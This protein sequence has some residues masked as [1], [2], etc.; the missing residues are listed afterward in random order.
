MKAIMGLEIHIHL[1]T[2]SKLFCSC[3]TDYEEKKP[4]ENTCPICLGFPGSKPKVNKSAIDFGITVAKALNC[5]ILSEMFFSRKSYFY[6]DMPKNFQ[7]SQ[8]E[9][10]LAVDGF[11]KISNKRINIRRIHL[12]EDPGKLIHVGGDITTAQ[13]VLVDYNRSGIPL[14]EVV[15]EP[16]F[17]STKEVREFLSKLSSILEH[18]EV[19]DSS[20]EGSMRV[21]ANISLAGGERV[22]LKNI[23]GFR[24]V[25]R[26]FNYEILRQKNLLRMGAKVER[27]TRHFDEISR[28]TKP[29]RK[30]EFEED[31]GYIFEPDLTEVEISREWTDTLEKK[32]PE[33]PEERAK[34]LVKEYK[35]RERE[36]GIIVYV[37]KALAD[38]FEQCCKIYKNYRELAKWI[39]ADLLKALNLAD[40]GIRE[41]KV[42]PEAFVELLVMI[43]KKIVTP[44]LAKEIIKEFVA[45]G[46][47]PKKIMKERKLRILSEEK[48]LN[49]IIKLVIRR[50]KKAV[51]DFLAG[52]ENALDFLI[53]EVMKKSKT[54]IDPKTA[55]V[56]LLKIIKKG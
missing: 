56:M 45:T 50:N 33:L 54:M 9:I 7:I 30:K 15:T 21:D 28:L 2:K 51:K 48:E 3:S 24:N 40:V 53:G 10:P 20:K 41:S 42:K 14:L 34:R 32:M 19:F 8:Y 1:L 26:A 44:R 18:L 17:T 4:N 6:P 55:K 46:K 39:V 12:E 29:L 16:D 11:L 31:Y 13:Y 22:E 49:R 5:K 38:F 43:D 37:D 25:E 23:S 35:I 47:S 36:A 27:E 52:R